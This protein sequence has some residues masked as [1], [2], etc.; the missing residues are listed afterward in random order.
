[1]KGFADKALLIMPKRESLEYR[2]LVTVLFQKTLDNLSTVLINRYGME[3]CTFS[4]HELLG[5]SIKIP[6]AISYVQSVHPADVY[7]VREKYPIPDSKY[8]YEEIYAEVNK[9]YPMKRGL[10]TDDR[11]TLIEKRD[12]KA[13]NLIFRRE[14]KVIFD[15]QVKGNKYISVNVKKHIGE[16]IYIEVDPLTAVVTNSYFCGEPRHIARI[17]GFNGAMNPIPEWEVDGK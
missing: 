16:H 14:F 7:T 5:L 10:S 9:A 1:M 8:L 2:Q 12:K 13:A 3:P 4:N 11:A 6:E 15:F 17:L